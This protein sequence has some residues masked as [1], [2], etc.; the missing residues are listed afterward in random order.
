VIN[1]QF[2]EARA[3]SL[4]LAPV[5]VGEAW[6]YIDKTGRFIWNPTT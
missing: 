5:A 6:G 4:G 2:D 3:F 1:P